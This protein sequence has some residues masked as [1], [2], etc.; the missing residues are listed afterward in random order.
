MKIRGMITSR[1]LWLII[2][3][4]LFA[5]F[6]QKANRAANE[7]TIIYIPSTR[8]GVQIGAP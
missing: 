1:W 8:P 3:C 5:G 4:A 2:L 6:V 7:P